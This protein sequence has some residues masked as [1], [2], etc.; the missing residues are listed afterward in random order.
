MK[1]LPRPLETGK[2][3]ENLYVVRDS[4]VN[5]YVYVKN[6]VVVCVDAGFGGT[7]LVRGFEKIAVSPASVGH[8]FLTHS[9]RDHVGGISLFVNAKVYMSKDE[10]QMINGKT[11]R[12]M[13]SYNKLPASQ[14]YTLLSDGDAV[15]A[16]GINVR[17]LETPGHTNGSMSYLIDESLLFTGDT[18]MLKEGKV[19]PTLR[20]MNMNTARQEES[21]RKL[22]KLKGVAFLCT[23]HS[24]YTADFDKAMA[25]WRS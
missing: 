7:D 18:L 21:I 11:P 16:G 14:H 10:E 20:L 1:F 12:M 24:G 3:A 22:A 25:T 15:N 2:I 9:D 6:G 17:A 4:H 23:A 8:L 5:L 19:V 13:W